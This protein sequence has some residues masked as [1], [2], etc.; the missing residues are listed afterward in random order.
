M[1]AI[2]VIGNRFRIIRFVPERG[3]QHHINTLRSD[4]NIILISCYVQNKRSRF[5]R[6]QFV[7]HRFVIAVESTA[8][9]TAPLDITGGGTFLSV[10]A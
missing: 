9:K 2:S 6:I 7:Q 3:P 10:T 1:L 8:K 5:M 4:I